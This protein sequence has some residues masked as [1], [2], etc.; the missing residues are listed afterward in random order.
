MVGISKSF[1]LWG[2]L[3]LVIV[4]FSMASLQ[5]EGLFRYVY[6]IVAIISSY[7]IRVTSKG[8]NKNDRK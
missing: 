6:F 4:F 7:I 1:F 3:T 8:D 5:S 2:L